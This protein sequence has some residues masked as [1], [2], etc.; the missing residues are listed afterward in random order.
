MGEIY[1][2]GGNDASSNHLKTVEKYT[3]S[4]DTWSGVAPLPAGRSCHVEVA[5]G[6]AMYVLGG[7]A[8]SSLLA[9]VLKFDSTQGT[10]SEVAP[11]P[12]VSSN[13]AAC[14]IGSNIYVFG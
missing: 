4:S 12:A 13:F 5:V 1:V 2:T 8:G 9:S 6:S 7:Y 14:V 11:M 3:P 10:W